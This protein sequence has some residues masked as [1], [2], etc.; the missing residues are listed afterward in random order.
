MGS[1]FDCIIN[2]LVK[3]CGV[4]VGLIYNETDWCVVIFI[5]VVAVLKYL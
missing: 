1:E 3:R 5:F 2:L 4:C